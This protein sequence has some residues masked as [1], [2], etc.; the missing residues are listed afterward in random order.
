MYLEI[1]MVES[2]NEELDNWEEMGRVLLP[3]GANKQQV[4]HAVAVLGVYAPRGN[5]DL[6]WGDF[7]VIYDSIGK[8]MVRLTPAAD[9][10]RTLLR[11][12]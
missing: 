12:E 4:E 2:F 3:F 1:F 5:D 9:V 8:A 6:E 7:A 10:E 11:R